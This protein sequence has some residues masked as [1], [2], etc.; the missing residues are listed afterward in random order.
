MVDEKDL[1]CPTC[2]KEMKEVSSDEVKLPL[3]MILSSL[4]PKTEISKLIFIQCPL[5]HHFKVLIPALSDEDR[6]KAAKSFRESL[7]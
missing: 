1:S 7:S 6:R 3:E 2:G 4:P 5:R